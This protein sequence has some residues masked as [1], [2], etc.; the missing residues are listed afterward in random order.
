MAHP[1]NGSYD[2]VVL[3]ASGLP[4]AEGILRGQ[5]VYTAYLDVGT[6]EVW[7][8]QF[9]LPNSGGD[10]APMEALTVTL[11]DPA[12]LK[13]PY[14]ILTVVPPS[15]QVARADFMM[16]HGY[17]DAHGRWRN[18]EVVDEDQKEFEQHTLPI[19][20]E[21]E[22]RPAALDG[23]AVEVEILLAIPPSQA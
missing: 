6:S 21:W 18:L 23:V 13:A 22:F 7:I 17:L 19:L 5:P 15:L 11:S 16:I 12:P 1:V 10:E 20:M 3:S 2:V 14:P 4:Q 9:A 8:L